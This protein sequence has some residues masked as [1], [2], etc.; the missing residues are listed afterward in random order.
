MQAPDGEDSYR[1]YS[2]LTSALDVVSD[3]RHAPAVLYTQ[4]RTPVPTG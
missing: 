3:Q 1:S 2:F 4:E